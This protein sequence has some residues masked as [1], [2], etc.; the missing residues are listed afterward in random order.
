MVDEGSQLRHD[1]S[2]T[3][4]IKK[5]SGQHRR[6]RFEHASESSGFYGYSGDRPRHLRKAHTLH[7]GAK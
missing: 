3:W 1:L 5:H 2:P 6:E 7:S 4:I